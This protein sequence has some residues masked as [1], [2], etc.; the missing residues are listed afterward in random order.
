MRSSRLEDNR[1]LEGRVYRT[2][3]AGCALRRRGRTASPRRVKELSE[4]RDDLAADIDAHATDAARQLWLTCVQ[5]FADD[6]KKLDDGVANLDMQFS[7]LATLREDVEGLCDNF[8][9]ALD[10]LA[11]PDDGAADAD[12]RARR[13]F[14]LR[15]GRRKR[16]SMDRSARWPI[17]AS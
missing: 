3:R 1:E 9:R 6:K 13:A 4:A 7:R 14:R 8:D 11:M 10:V 5:T 15:Q 2:A 16:A 17:S 12:A